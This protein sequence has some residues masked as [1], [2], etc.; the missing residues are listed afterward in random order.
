MSMHA[1]F[2]RAAARGEIRASLDIELLLDRLAGPFYFRRLF[3]H[4][5]LKEILVHKIVDYILLAAARS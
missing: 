1:A 2:V 5:S 3:G 4:Q